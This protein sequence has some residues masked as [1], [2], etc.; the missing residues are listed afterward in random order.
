MV[1][2]KISIDNH[3]RNH[4][5]IAFHF[6]ICVNHNKDNYYYFLTEAISGPLSP[7]RQEGLLGFLE[8]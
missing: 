3:L 4:F 6:V 7:L 1:N 2:R 5:R 8:L